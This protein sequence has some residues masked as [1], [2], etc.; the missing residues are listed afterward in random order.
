MKLEREWE[1]TK[2]ELARLYRAAQRLCRSKED[3]EDIVF[4][5]LSRAVIHTETLLG[6]TPQRRE[7]WLFTALAREA[8]R[9]YR[10]SQYKYKFL[11]AEECEKIITSPVDSEEIRSFR[12]R[13]HKLREAFKRIPSCAHRAVLASVFPAEV[14]HL[15]PSRFP[16][17]EY[18]II[19]LDDVLKTALESSDSAKLLDIPELQILWC[20]T[21]P[22]SFS[23][24]RQVWTVQYR[25]LYPQD[26]D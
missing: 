25:T 20:G 11:V 18:S 17:R 4:G 10:K 12:E 15:R 5:V 21:K 2:D 16:Y 14:G 23:R 7:N 22:V 24:A 26:E 6:L 9:E 8:S 13:L 1:P 19:D 3:A